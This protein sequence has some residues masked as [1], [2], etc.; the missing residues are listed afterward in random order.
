MNMFDKGPQQ[1]AMQILSHD[2]H[3]T[4]SGLRA[5]ARDLSKLPDGS[6]YSQRLLNVE[7]QLTKK[8]DAYIT[9][10]NADFPERSE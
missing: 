6:S 2:F 10:F 1:Q 4:L 3:Q 8:L 7:K 9:E 5:V